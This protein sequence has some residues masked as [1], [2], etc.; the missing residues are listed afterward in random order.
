MLRARR[1]ARL[2]VLQQ[3]LGVAHFF[4]GLGHMPRYMDSKEAKTTFFLIQARQE[5]FQAKSARRL[6]RYV[7]SAPSVANAS[8]G[9]SRLSCVVLKS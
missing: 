1:E 2:E 9:A 6:L 7:S 3:V 4:W 8:L 5:E